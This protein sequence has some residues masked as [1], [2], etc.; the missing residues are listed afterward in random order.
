MEGRCPEK[1]APF[2][3]A[4]GNGGRAALQYWEELKTANITVKAVSVSHGF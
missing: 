4:C 1:R 2:I 3:T